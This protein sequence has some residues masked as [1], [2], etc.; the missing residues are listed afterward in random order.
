MA[1]DTVSLSSIRVSVINLITLAVMFN[2]AI[3]GSTFID[4]SSANG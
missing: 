1:L 4:M 2:L 3:F